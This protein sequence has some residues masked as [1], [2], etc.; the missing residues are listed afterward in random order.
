K[1]ISAMVENRPDWCISRQR[2]WGIP[3]PAFY[4]VESG[5]TCIDTE[6]V[7]HVISLVTQ[8]GSNVWYDDANWPVEKLL[9]DAVRPDKFKGRKLA[10]MDDIFDVWFES[11]ASHRAV[12]LADDELKDK[13]PAN[14]YL[15]GDDQHR[16]WF[17]VS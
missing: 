14:L 15:E 2:F 10:K 6:T 1:R 7:D 12:M 11:G 17:Q 9:P 3:I 13:F 16:G 4:D 5:E 8:H